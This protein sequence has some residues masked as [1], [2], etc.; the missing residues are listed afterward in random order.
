ML[1]VESDT[2]AMAAPT[3]TLAKGESSCVHQ[4]AS[5]FLYFCFSGPQPIGQ[6]DPHSRM[7]PPTQLPLHTSV[8]SN[9]TFRDAPASVLYWSIYPSV[10]FHWKSRLTT[11]R[12]ILKSILNYYFMLWIFWKGAWCKFFPVCNISAHTA[13]QFWLLSIKP[14]LLLSDLTQWL[15]ALAALQRDP[16]LVSNT[17]MVATAICNSISRDLMPPPDF[18][19]HTHGTHTHLQAKH[20]YT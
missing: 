11:T 8:I 20:P 19:G 7:V 6:W 1:K 14:K 16:G 18:Q 17:H 4:L 2:Q 5:S 9:Y 15:T 12:H 3:G 13:Y 10:L